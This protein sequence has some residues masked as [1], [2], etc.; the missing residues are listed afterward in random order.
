MAVTF[1]VPSKGSFREGFFP[2]LYPT[3]SESTCVEETWVLVSVPKAGLDPPAKVSASAEAMSIRP[4]GAKRDFPTPRRDPL[5][6]ACFP[7]IIGV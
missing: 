5:A 3:I 6:V 7:T 4:S 1:F 2:D